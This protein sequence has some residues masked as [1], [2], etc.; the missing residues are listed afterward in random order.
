MTE[1]ICSVKQSV[2]KSGPLSRDGKFMAELDIVKDLAKQALTIPTLTGDF[3]NSLWD[4]AQRLVRNVEHICRL[5]ELGKTSL[6]IDRFSLYAATYFSDAGLARHLK[7]KETGGKSVISNTNGNDL[8]DFCTQIVEEKLED[9][10]DKTKIKKINRIITESCSRFTRM[11]EAMILSDARNLDD[12]GAT[13]IFNEFRRFVSHGKGASD[14]LKGWER[15]IDYGYWQARL[16]EGFR[17]EAVRKLAE[18]RLAAAE[19]FMN[20]LNVENTAQDL[21]ELTIESLGEK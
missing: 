18:Q 21:G 5:P 3:D 1:Y 20:Q 16:K 7:T 9:A 6:Q 2:A 14:A 13:G 4:R 12:T 15:K 11:T 19:Y 10:I 8:L 17:F